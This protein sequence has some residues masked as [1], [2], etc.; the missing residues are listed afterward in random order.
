M[1]SPLTSNVELV[2]SLLLLAPVNELYFVGVLIPE[3]DSS[4]RVRRVFAVGDS[5][6]GIKT[7]DGLVSLPSLRMFSAECDILTLAS[8]VIYADLFISNIKIPNY[9]IIAIKIK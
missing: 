9:Y 2:L 1:L 5:V 8:S 7:S 6:L 3:G 4:P